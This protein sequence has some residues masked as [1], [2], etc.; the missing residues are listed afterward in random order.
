[1]GKRKKVPNVV[2]VDVGDYLPVLVHRTSK[3]GRRVDR[4][5]HHVPTPTPQKNLPTPTFN[6]SPVFEDTAGHTFPDADVDKPM[7]ESGGSER[8]RTRFPLHGAS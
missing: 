1:M 7:G 8:V 3:D 6:P 2:K 4:A 5:V